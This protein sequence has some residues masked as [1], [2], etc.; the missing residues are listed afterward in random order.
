MGAIASTVASAAGPIIGNLAK[1]FLP[2]LLGGVAKGAASGGLGGVLG[3]ASSALAGA[4][5]GALQ[6][7]SQ[8]L[9]GLL[10]SSGKGFL[11]NITSLIPQLVN[12]LTSKFVGR[13]PNIESA[14]ERKY[15]T[16]G[17]AA[18]AILDVAK[19]SLLKAFEN[20]REEEEIF[21]D[22]EEGDESSLFK[23][24]LSSLSGGLG[25]VFG[26]LGGF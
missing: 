18:G 6:G 14:L 8:V 24:L 15:G 20:P 22:A 13:D 11:S 1:T 16:K 7:A 4:G 2:G 10:Q 9:P 19:G 26:G 23:T 21:Y 5:R 17:K 12:S 3:G 25:K